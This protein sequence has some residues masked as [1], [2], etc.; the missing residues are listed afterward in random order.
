MVIERLPLPQAPLGVQLMC[1]D[2]PDV[3]NKSATVKAAAETLTHQHTSSSSIS[4]P[5]KRAPEL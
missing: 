3:Q 4:S 2:R 1:H 5:R